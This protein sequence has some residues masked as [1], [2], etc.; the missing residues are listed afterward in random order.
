MKDPTPGP[1]ARSL[2]AAIPLLAALVAGCET[3]GPAIE[4][5]ALAVVEW[6]PLGELSDGIKIHNGG[7]GSAIVLHPARTGYFYLLTDR[8]PNIDTEW[9]TNKRFVYPSFA[10]HI[11]L[12][13]LDGTRLVRVAVIELKDAAG[14]R[15]TGLPNPPVRDGTGEMAVDLQGKALPLDPDGIDSEGLVAM[16][17]GS[18]WVSDEY[19]PHLLHVDG[20]GRTVERISPA[21]KNREGHALPS[22]FA[23]RR[24]NRGMEGLSIT[25]DG[26]TLVGIM[27]S[28]LGNPSAVVGK[29]TRAARLLMYDLVTGA[30]QQFVY[31]QEQPDLSNSA[32]A[33]LSRTEF[34]VLERN[35]SF[36]GNLA[37]GACCKRIYRID[38]ANAT[39]LSDPADGANG[40]LFNGKTLEQLA[41]AELRSAGI[42]PAAKTLLLDLLSLPG[43]YPH[44][45]PEGLAIV[46]P[47][48]LAVSNDDDFG[49]TG[50]ESGALVQKILPAAGSIERSEVYFLRLTAPLP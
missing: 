24:P 2:S 22:V 19:G 38:V 10:P 47:Q 41:D 9:S 27:Q 18:F 35:D 49:I 43:G 36:G 42:V 21:V 50:D 30:T 13:K 23:T 29:T 14:R 44:D 7:Y 40:R 37:A 5:P 45:K 48:L 6:R 15:L 33:A 32:I 46:G 4:Y 20:S 26:R 12:F 39:D 31:L 11:G 34:L 25:P 8:G 17:D 1:K 3:S 16:K 28:A